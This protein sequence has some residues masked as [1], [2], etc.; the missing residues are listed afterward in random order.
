MYIYILLYYENLDKQV[1]KYFFPTVYMLVPIIQN[2]NTSDHPPPPHPYYF[3]K[4]RQTY[5][6]SGGL[7]LMI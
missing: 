1:S 5:I 3:I 7:G 2:Y 4:Y 6:C